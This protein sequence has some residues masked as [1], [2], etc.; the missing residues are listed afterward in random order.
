MKFVCAHCGDWC[1]I[2]TTFL[3]SG[4]VL[5]CPECDKDTVVQLVRKEASD[6]TP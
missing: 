5:H 6:E 2:E 4:T 3:D 1:H